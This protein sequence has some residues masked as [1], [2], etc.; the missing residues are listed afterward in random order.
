MNQTPDESS[1]IDAQDIAILM[2]RDAHFGGKFEFMIDYYEK[3]GKGIF[4][5]FDIE[6]IR[7]LHEMEKR[8]EQ[9]LA[10]LLLSGSDAERVGQAKT[11]YKKLRDLYEMTSQKSG[12]TQAQYPRLIADLILSEEEEP[13]QEM[14]AI[15]AEKEAIVPALLDLVRAEDFYDPLF[16][17]YGLAPLLAA[18]CLGRI[19]D[20]R[21]VVALFE[22]IGEK[23]FINEDLALDALKAIGDPAK[24]FLLKVLHGTPITYDNE[25]AAVALLSFQDDPQVVD[26]AFAMLKKID[27]KQHLL[28]ASHL[29]LIC[30]GLTKPEERKEFLALE[31]KPAT[32]SMLKSDI[33][34]IGNHWAML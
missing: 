17:G 8:L 14:E 32:P 11:A 29:V 1:L 22:L 23:D 25:R 2:H 21:A 12:V 33:K 4:P 19:G 28:L 18:K 30:E 20:K 6:R 16:P 31:E 5:E 3:E 34:T 27:M 26:T 13:E 10:P 15:I 24:S 9:N 7:E